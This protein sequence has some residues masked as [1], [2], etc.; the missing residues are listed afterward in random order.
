V[1]PSFWNLLV[2]N[3]NITREFIDCKLLG[4]IHGVLAILT[5][6]PDIQ[7]E[8]NLFSDNS[9]DRRVFLVTAV[10]E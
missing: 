7:E 5:N 6:S 8:H 3:E 4:Q 9:F 1:Q 2:F 10:I